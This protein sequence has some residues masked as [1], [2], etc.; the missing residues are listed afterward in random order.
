M[1]RVRVGLTT[2]GTVQFAATMSLVE[3]LAR[4]QAFLAVQDGLNAENL[5]KDPTFT[6]GVKDIA[7]WTK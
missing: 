4:A 7:G 1:R 6:L 3:A 2:G 5:P